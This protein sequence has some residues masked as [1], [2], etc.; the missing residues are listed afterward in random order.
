MAHSDSHLGDTVTF[1]TKE[2]HIYSLLYWFIDPSQPD[3]GLQC[4]TQYAFN[5]VMEVKGE[6]FPYKYTPQ[7]DFSMSIRVFLHLIVKL[8]NALLKGELPEFVVKAIYFDCH[9]YTTKYTLYQ[10]GTE[11]DSKQHEEL[12]Q[13]KE[14]H[15]TGVN[16]RQ[17]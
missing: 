15:R 11:P 12:P 2:N 17:T 7:S 9:F 1:I 14:E 3:K 5:L 6:K 13:K 8:S 4:G 10:R 16:G